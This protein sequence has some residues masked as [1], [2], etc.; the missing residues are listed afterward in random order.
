M[1]ALYA[2]DGLLVSPAGALVRGRAALQDYYAKRFASGA[3]GHAIK[4]TEVHV[5]GDGGYSVAQFSV[6]VPK[7]GGETEEVHG[8]IVAVYQHDPDGWHL[9]LVQPSVPEPPAK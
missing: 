5:Q 6:S 2:K 4:V 9:S 1:A 3:H 8:S 7:P